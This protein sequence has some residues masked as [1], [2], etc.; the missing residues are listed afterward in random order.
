MPKPC[1]TCFGLPYILNPNKSSYIQKESFP[2]AQQVMW[3][4]LKKIF[5]SRFSQLAARQD[6]K[7]ML[8][9]SRK[10]PAETIFWEAV[11]SGLLL[12]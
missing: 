1:S 5:V 8:G 3:A 12:A 2:R 9:R 4:F 10:Y 7:D 11:M 6:P